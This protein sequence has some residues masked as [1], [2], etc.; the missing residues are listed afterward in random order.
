VAC[1]QRHELI[2]VEVEERIGADEE[3]DPNCAFAHA[4]IGVSHAF[5]GERDL[6]LR[7]CDEAM[8]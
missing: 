3:L 5:A 1:G 8:R 4:Y 2:P 6:V 7:H